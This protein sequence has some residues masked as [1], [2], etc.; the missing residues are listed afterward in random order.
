M[1]FSALTFGKGLGL[2]NSTL[3][4]KKV[5]PNDH[6]VNKTGRAL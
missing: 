6:L 2:V 3:G 1:R 4:W 5:V